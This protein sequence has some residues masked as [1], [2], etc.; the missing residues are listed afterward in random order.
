MIFKSAIPENRR[1]IY[2]H[3]NEPTLVAVGGRI[4]LFPVP[5]KD[6]EEEV[7]NIKCFSCG[8]EVSVRKKDTKNCDRFWCRHECMS[9]NPW[10]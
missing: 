4:T 9:E 10:D 3:E 1:L 6:N 7:I 2:A 5:K 8:L